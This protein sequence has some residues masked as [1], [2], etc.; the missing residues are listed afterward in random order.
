MQFNI[1]QRKSLA[2]FFNSLAVAWFVALFATPSVA[3]DVSLL[4]LIQ[5]LVNMLLALFFS[6]YFLKD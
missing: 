2:A 6:L 4:T 3:K 1:E 5:Y